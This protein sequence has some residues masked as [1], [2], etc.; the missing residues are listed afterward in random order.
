MRAVVLEY[1]LKRD[2]MVVAAAILALTALAWAYVLWTAASMPTVASVIS[3]PGMVMTPAGSG[4]R[5][6]A[7]TSAMWVVMMIGMMTP[8]AA[9]MILLYARVGRQARADG[10]PFAST[11]WFA[12]GFFLPLGGFCFSPRLGP[13]GLRDQALI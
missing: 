5:G 10:R 12:G 13:V 8:S 2:R 6:F 3:M 4:I 1:V 7:F 9:P 11:G